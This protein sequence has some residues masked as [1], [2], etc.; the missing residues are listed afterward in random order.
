MIENEEARA[1]RPNRNEG[2]CDVRTATL[3]VVLFAI[4]IGTGRVVAQQPA[5]HVSGVGASPYLPPPDIASSAVNF[6]RVVGW[7][8]GR[9]PEAPAG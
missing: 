7:P 2:W 6:P 8:E 3:F 1:S 4:Q 9:M 5:A